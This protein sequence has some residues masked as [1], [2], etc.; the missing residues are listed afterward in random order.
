MLARTQLDAGHPAAAPALGAYAAGREVQQLRVGGDEAQHL[1]AGEQLDGTDDLVVVLEADDVPLVAAHDLRVDPL[2]H[3][4]A[5]AER[6]TGS[7]AR[8]RRQGQ[9]AFADPEGQDLAERQPALEVGVVG[10]VR[11]LGH[12]EHADLDEAAPTGQHADLAAGGGADGAHDHVVVGPALA[13]AGLLDRGRTREQ[14]AGG[15]V[16]EARFVG[17]LDRGRGRRGDGRPG[18]GEEHGTAGGAVGLGD[19][20]QLLGDD[21][22]QQLLVGQDR[23]E[24]LDRALQLVLLLVELELGEPGEATQRHVEDVV[25]LG[26]GELEDRDQSLLGRGGVVG[27]PDDLD[28]LVDVEDRDEEAVDEVEAVGGLGAAVQRATAYDVE[29]VGEE[30]LE[31]LDQAERARLAVDEGHGVDAEGVLER[32][33]AVELLEQC[34]GDEAV[35]HLDDQAQAVLA[36][37]EVLDVGDPLEL[38]GQDELLDLLHHPLGAHAVGQL[39]DHDALATGRHRLDARGG[40]HPEGAAA[41]LVGVADAVEPDD[42]A[43]RGQVGAGDEAHQVV[44][45]GPRVGDQV[46]QRLDHLDEVVRRDVGGHPYR[47]PGG[48][49]DEQVRDGSGQ[50]DRL[51]LAGVVV[52]LEVD[53]VLVDRCRHRDGGGAHPALGVAHGGG[54]VVGRA[55]VAVPVDGREP[56]RPVL[57]HPDERVVDRAVAVRVEAAHDLAH[58]ARALDVAA[59]GA[60]SHL[61]HRV[62]DAALHRLEPVAGV[63]EG[64]GVDDGVGVLQ[65]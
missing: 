41:R 26:L 22:P 51:G 35:L 43:A 62:E 30:D 34:L 50:D 8:Q 61:V 54:G 65:E 53:G 16:G 33:L 47:D 38:L 20:G 44:E 13:A 21:L 63:G 59:V 60:Q 25:G 52:G 32:G 28:D 1:V 3:T 10:R 19:L 46:A 24:Q 64:A 7:V 37:G 9:G 58:D 40:A 36:V 45:G 11:Q 48:A 31:H 57:G 15:E 39:G 14:A 29:A 12:V 4:G 5:C 2:H 49:V 18:R 23:V 56:H 6:E 27:G 42:L 55:E 17:H